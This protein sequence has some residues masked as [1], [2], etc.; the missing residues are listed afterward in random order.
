MEENTSS[1]ARCDLIR[2]NSES[3]LDPLKLL[4]Y[5]LRRFRS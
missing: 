3:K 1:V 4:F 5:P 2:E